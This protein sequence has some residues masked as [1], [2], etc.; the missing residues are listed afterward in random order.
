MM[1]NKQIDVSL[2]SQVV[3]RAGKGAVYAVQTCLKFSEER[4]VSRFQFWPEDFDAICASL[5]DSGFRADGFY[6][7]NIK[8]VR[9]SKRG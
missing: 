2:H 8:A 6:V 7:G 4:E 3:A 1:S 5:K 9:Y